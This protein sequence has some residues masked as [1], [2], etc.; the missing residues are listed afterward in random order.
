M[1]VWP[2][3]VR[4][5]ALTMA[6]SYTRECLAI[7]VDSSVSSRRVSRVLEWIISQR[8]APEPLRCDN[9]T[10]FTSRHYLSWCE[11][12]KLRVTHIQPVKPRQVSIQCSVAWNQGS[13]GS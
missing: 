13:M 8:G 9:G 1:T 2:R 7:D 4:L 3:G 6:D 10:E 11:E 12:R 5:R